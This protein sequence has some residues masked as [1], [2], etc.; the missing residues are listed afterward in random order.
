MFVLRPFMYLNVGSPLR[1]EEGFVFMS[2]RDTCCTVLWLLALTVWPRHGPCREH[3]FQQYL[4]F[5]IAY[6]L[7]RKPVYPAVV[8]QRTMYSCHN[9]VTCR[10]VVHAT[11]MTGSIS[12]DWIY[13]HWGYTFTPNYTYI[14][15]YS[16]IAHLHQLP[17]TV[18][19]ALGFLCLR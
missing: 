6:L 14:Q 5:L 11:I 16:V 12:D 3:C 18:A 19:H 8:S 4:W 9:I 17:T 10:M 7:P 15:Q 13:Q 1:R 2:R